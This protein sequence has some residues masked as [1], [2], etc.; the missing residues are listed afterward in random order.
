VK[1]IAAKNR[2]LI[3]KAKEV[4]NKFVKCGLKHLD[5]SYCEKQIAPDLKNLKE[6]FLRVNEDSSKRI[7]DTVRDVI[8]KCIPLSL[9][10]VMA[11]SLLA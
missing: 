4:W 10:S 5:I 7:A 9:L 11:P 2:Q 8:E 6:E 3:Q 1:D